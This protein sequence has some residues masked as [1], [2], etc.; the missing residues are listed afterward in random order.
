MRRSSKPVAKQTAHGPPCQHPLPKTPPMTADRNPN[1]LHD[2][3]ADPDADCVVSED[4]ATLRS[5]ELDA[6]SSI[7][8]PDRRDRLAEILTDD[9]VATLKHLAKEGM[10]ANSLRALASDL[11]YLET[12]A[13]AALGHPLPW[14][15]PEALILK[16][17][18][19]HLYDP[20]LKETDPAHG[21]PVDIAQRLKANGCL[22]TQGPHAPNTVRR[23]LALW[24][25]LHRWRGVEGAFASQHIRAAVRLAVRAANRPPASKS[26]DAVTRDILDRLLATCHA[27]TIVDIRDRALLLV[28]FGS[29]GRRRS[30]VAKLRIDDLVD[31]PPVPAD[32]EQPDGGT[33]PCLALRLG[34]TKT[35]GVDADERVI[36]IGRPVLALKTWI[37]LAPI[38][39]GALFRSIDRFGRVGRTALDGQSINAILK[40]RVLAAGLDPQKYS[41]H[42]LRSGYL[43]E[44]ARQG[45]PIQAAMRQSRHR[46]VQQAAEYFN[47]AEVE[48]GQSARLA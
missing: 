19:H 18:A 31:R 9:D 5:Y 40:K 8:P 22:R 36:L 37:A 13:Q 26:Q 32:P 21:M 28:A 27:D 6:L 41:A 17:L 14:P 7:L 25:T 33:L 15:A 43:T 20:R 42:G 12:W 29:G 4:L 1:G 38:R 39:S 45:V 16:F 3:I 2:P 24:S 44:A 46:S 48:R 35:A 11:N 23:R 47:D 34:R 10:G 30:E